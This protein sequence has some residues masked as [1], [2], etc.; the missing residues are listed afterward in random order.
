[1][2]LTNG[3]SDGSEP[4]IL[5]PDEFAHARN[6]KRGRRKT[7]EE[8]LRSSKEMKKKKIEGKK[9]VSTSSTRCK[10]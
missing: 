8:L 6:P 1:M 4:S 9:V 10:V 2:R 3:G 5:V 7:I